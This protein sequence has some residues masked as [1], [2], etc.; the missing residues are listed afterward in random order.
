MKDRIIE[1]IVSSHKMSTETK[2]FIEPG[3]GVALE[4][5]LKKGSQREFGEEMFN[6]GF[7]AMETLL[8]RNRMIHLDGRKNEQEQK[9]G[10]IQMF[11]DR[12]HNQNRK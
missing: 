3:D 6:R 9:E 1:L 12:L 2:M 4:R 8:G 10:N 7:D 5:F 11:N